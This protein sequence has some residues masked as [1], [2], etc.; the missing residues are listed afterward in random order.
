[1]KIFEDHFY[2]IDRQCLLYFENILIYLLGSAKLLMIRGFY[3]NLKIYVRFLF[4]IIH[5]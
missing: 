1:M 2:F 3:T 5:E 4:K